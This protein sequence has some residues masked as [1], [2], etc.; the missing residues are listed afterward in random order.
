MK[1]LFI[2]GGLWLACTASA[3]SQNG[4]GYWKRLQKTHPETTLEALTTP[5]VSQAPSGQTDL[6]ACRL[7][8]VYEGK[9]RNITMENIQQMKESG[10]KPSDIRQY[11]KEILFTSADKEI[12]LPVKSALVEQLAI[13]VAENEPVLLYT[14]VLQ[15]KDPQENQ[16]TLLVEEYQVK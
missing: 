14:T 9:T 10:L 15:D 3:F 6:P 7:S 16:V 1:K 13:E 8:M 11:R 5:A 12:W 2:L 4:D